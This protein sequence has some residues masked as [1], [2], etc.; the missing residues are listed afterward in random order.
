[1]P[2]A[3]DHEL[4][5]TFTPTDTGAYFTPPPVTKTV[6]VAKASS[7]TTLTAS[8]ATSE[9]GQAVTFTATVT[10]QIAGVPATGTVLF[11]SGDLVLGSD[12]LED[13]V[14][15]VTTSSLPIG[16]NPV[17]ATYSGDDNVMGSPG[18]TTQAVTKVQTTI[19]AREGLPALLIIGNN[20]MRATLT[21]TRDGAP[22]ADRLILFTQGTRR[23]CSARTN[24][25][26][27]AQCSTFVVSL[28]GLG[29]RYLASF[30]GDSTYVPS[31]TSG[32]H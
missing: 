4:T 12:M 16:S 15:S 29:S 26:G 27:T 18:S 14:A 31:I 13:G 7:T 22:I 32:R 1:V 28:L 21:R 9:L 19:V 8:P 2:L 3:G 24:A 23:L 11:T 25:S 17:L 6:T 5:A 30:D 10:P 20:T